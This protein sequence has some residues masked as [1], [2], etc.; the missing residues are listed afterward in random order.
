MQ[1]QAPSV[2]FLASLATALDVNPTWLLTGEG[3]MRYS[4]VRAAALAEAEIPEIV[5][6]ISRAISEYFERSTMPDTSFRTREPGVKHG[7]R[8]LNAGLGGSRSFQRASR[9]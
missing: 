8:E 4:Q 5:A 3:P 2:Q 9:A 6:A 7:H 1:G